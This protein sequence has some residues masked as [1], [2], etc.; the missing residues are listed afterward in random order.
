MANTIPRK[1]EETLA[2]LDLMIA[3]VEKNR[4]DLGGYADELLKRF[5]P[6][7]DN[8]RAAILKRTETAGLARRATQELHAT[9]RTAVQSAQQFRFLLYARYGK[10]NAILR[11]FGLRTL[12]NRWMSR[13]KKTD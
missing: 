8:L 13:K 2:L 9:T 3:G 6:I 1:P 5:V 10:Q 11:G 4:A 7:R 12:K